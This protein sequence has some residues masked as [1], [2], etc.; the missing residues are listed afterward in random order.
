[1]WKAFYG[2]F[3]FYTVP[4][5]ACCETVSQNPVVCWDDMRAQG[6]SKYLVMHMH[7][8]DQVGAMA[9]HSYDELGKFIWC[10]PKT[11]EFFTAAGSDQKCLCG[12]DNEVGEVGDETDEEMIVL[13][14]YCVVP[15]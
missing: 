3:S 4:H 2:A 1:M 7:I 8:F 11:K 13:P 5:W 10:F 6:D 9:C 12:C 14:C 15:A